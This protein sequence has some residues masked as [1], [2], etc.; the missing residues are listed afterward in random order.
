LLRP[1]VQ[2]GPL[3]TR[4]DL[5][6]AEVFPD[7]PIHELFSHIRPDLL[8]RTDDDV[9]NTWDEIGDDVRDQ[10][11][12]G[13]LKIWGRV[14]RDGADKLLGQRQALRLIEPSYWTMAFFTYSFF[15]NTAGDA[16]HTYLEYGRSGAVYTDLQVNKNQA[17]SIWTQGNL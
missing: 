6:T 8:I 2:R 16:P 5:T 10:A 11:A 4:R 14:V 15:D 3:A 13:R 9:G 12:I 17:Q 7:W 1:A